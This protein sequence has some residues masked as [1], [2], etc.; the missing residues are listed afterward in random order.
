[1]SSLSKKL[2]LVQSK[3]AKKLFVL[4]FLLGPFNVCGQHSFLFK[5]QPADKIIHTI[6]DSMGVVFNFDNSVIS[7]DEKYHFGITGQLQD[8]L[9]ALSSTLDLDIR[10]LEENLYV[11]HPASSGQKTE[12]P[13][14]KLR[15]IDE[16]TEVLAA[17]LIQMESRGQAFTSNA[18]GE[19]LIDGFFADQESLLISY[20]GYK[21]LNVPF[22]KLSEA[23]EPNIIVLE[24]A[25]FM[26]GEILIKDKA[27]LSHLENLNQQD[28][29]NL[30]P[31]E[32]LSSGSRDG[33]NL[34]QNI[35]GVY[36]STE[37]I[38]DIQIRGGPPDQTHLSWNNIKIFQPS[39][40]YG[41]VSSINPFMVDE[42]AIN[43]NGGASS[44]A[45]YAASGI[46]IKS[47]NSPNDETTLKIYSDLLYSNISLSIPLLND[48]LNVKAAYRKSWAPTFKSPVY[49]SYINNTFQFG[50]VADD[51]FYYQ[52]FNLE[53]NYEYSSDF[54]FRDF[55][56]SVNAE[57]LRDLNLQFNYLDVG[58]DFEYSRTGDGLE[59]LYDFGMKNKGLSLLLDKRWG[60]LQK[61]EISY[62][63]SDF[64]Y[65]Y[66]YYQNIPDP[67][68]YDFQLLSNDVSQSHIDWVHQIKWRGSIF[69][70]GSTYSTWSARYMVDE[71]GDFYDGQ[72]ID[73]NNESH[74]ISAFAEWN[75]EYKFLKLQ[76]GLRWSD[77]SL[78]HSNR[79]FLEPKIHAEISLAEGLSWQLHYGQYHQVLNR[80]MINTP[81]EADNGFWYVSDE[82]NNSDNWI[83]VIQNEQW[84]TGLKYRKQLFSFEIEAYQKTIEDLWTSAYEL[85]WEENPYRFVDSNIKGIELSSG[86]EINNWMGMITLNAMID[87]FEDDEGEVR[88]SPFYQPLRLGLN[89]HWQWG[90][91]NVWLRWQFAKG[92]Y[93]SVPTGLAELFDDNGESYYV[94][95]YG[96]LLTEQGPDYHRLDL[97]LTYTLPFK[98]NRYC[99]LG[100]DFINLY[101]RKNVTRTFYFTDFKVNPNRVSFFQ[102]QGLPMVPNFSIE[103]VF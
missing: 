10:S 54:N 38:N 46:E 65:A 56:V 42:I 55:S 66:D 95:T 100:L 67:D 96:D 103:W 35:V 90:R 57:V 87:E 27:I 84:S 61:T 24:K 23:S 11:L 9:N 34:A 52:Q 79:K 85:T 62:T 71:E 29:V 15:I 19:L 98:S 40:F 76:T 63:Q 86:V 64:N 59:S 68:N 17:C 72:F 14:Y 92:R 18:N 89:S 82:G 36:N 99:K 20:L 22:S 51:S 91:I 83:H 5:N 50:Q 41:R 75:W 53:G 28:L 80:R 77:Y 102:R 16:Q 6:E 81:L 3:H 45:S 32:N 7:Q 74:E 33:L 8:V 58:N 73:D 21:D 44:S 69:K 4:F 31:F 48:K 26:I 30:E 12:I 49:E 25:E 97:S 70:L 88:K 60:A 101:G 43:K 2:F 93:Y 39:L 37:S 13:I 78:V 47:D 94:T 1:M